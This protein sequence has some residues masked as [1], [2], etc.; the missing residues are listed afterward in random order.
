[1][2]M[3][4]VTLLYH[5]AVNNFAG[6]DES[7]FPGSGA[8]PYKLDES[9]MIEHFRAIKQIPGRSVGLITEILQEPSDSLPCPLLLTFDDGGKSAA[10]LISRMLDLLGW[11][12][13]FF[14]TTDFIGTPGFMSEDEIQGLRQAGHI[15]GSHSASHPLRMAS[16]DRPTLLREWKASVAQLEEILGEPTTTASVPGGFFSRAVAETAGEA[17]IQVLFTSEPIKRV[18]R[19]GNC[20]V[21][22]RYNLWRGMKPSVSAALSSPGLS[23][24]QARQYLLWNTKKILK[25]AG[26]RHYL[27]WRGRIL[28]RL[29]SK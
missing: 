24:A 20:L 5:D 15:I 4:A 14:I 13:H 16:C 2:T 21:M 19:I 22:G 12:A 17:G 29:K 3:K 27:T 11:K 23:L 25:N 8:A 7:G 6:I 1:M 10:T 9:D 18:E 28:A 26:G